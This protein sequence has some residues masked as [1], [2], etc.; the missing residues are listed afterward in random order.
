VKVTFL[1]LLSAALL[2]AGSGCGDGSDRLS[3]DEFV[4]QAD[5][6]CAKYEN[7]LLALGDLPQNTEDVDEYA[8]RARPIVEAGWNEQKA[9][10]PPED[11]QDEYDKWIATGEDALE[12]IDEL[13]EA[14]AAGDTQRVAELFQ[15]AEAR[16]QENEQLSRAMGL[17]D[18]GVEGR[19]E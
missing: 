17:R 18:C 15:Q 7:E 4:E 2:A 8:Q 9:L 11:L 3:R 5:A 14:G 6:N 16:V 19:R 13:H 10:K 12:F 1:M